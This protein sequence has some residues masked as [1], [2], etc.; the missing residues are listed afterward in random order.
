MKGTYKCVALFLLAVQYGSIPPRCMVE[1]NIHATTLFALT[2]GRVST[3]ITYRP[4]LVSEDASYGIGE[5][6]KLYGVGRAPEIPKCGSA[7]QQDTFARVQ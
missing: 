3:H 7:T 1:A 6:P 5:V 2:H 4:H